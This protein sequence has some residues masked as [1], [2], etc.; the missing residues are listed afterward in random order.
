METGRARFA[1]S[2]VRRSASI[3]MIR[4]ILPPNLRTLAHVDGQLG[5]ELNGMVPQPGLL[6]ACDAKLP[7]PRGALRDRVTHGRRR[8][9]RFLACG[10]ELA[11]EPPD[12]PLP[13]AMPKGAGPFLIRG[14]IDGGYV[15]AVSGRGGAV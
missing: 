13:E 14:P 9:V 3:A 12:A 4:V 5:V 1:C 15:P 10:E 7:L 11:H 8:M 2:A 6:E